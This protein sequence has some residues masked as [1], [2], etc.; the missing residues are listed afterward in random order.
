MSKAGTFSFE[1]IKDL[2][3]TT[4]AG[5]EEG[6]SSTPFVETKEINNVP[7]NSKA[8][9]ICKDV[10]KMIFKKPDATE[11][12][13]VKYL[14]TEYSMTN[15]EIE[16]FQ[17]ICKLETNTQAE[18]ICKDVK[19]MILVHPDATENQV[20]TY[21][22]TKYAMTNHE[23]E[24]FQKMCH[25]EINEDNRLQQKEDDEQVRIQESSKQQEKEETKQEKA[26][27][28]RTKEEETEDDASPRIKRFKSEWIRR[29][30]E[31]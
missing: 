9:I 5:E 2:R 21:L 6:N 20:V 24:I 11:K 16:G 22:Q 12:Q 30:Y 17:R 27:T 26:N 3:Q 23:I 31:C 13:V 18:S 25:I 15:H 19:N 4:A 10:Q 8:K 7:E 1:Y 28:A 29:S 14:Q